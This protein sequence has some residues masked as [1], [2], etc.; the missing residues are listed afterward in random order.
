MDRGLTRQ[1]LLERL[2]VLEQEE[3]R[4]KDAERFAE[5]VL[6][7]LSAHIAIL[8]QDG[9]IIETNR[10]WK[11]FAHAN[12]IRMRPD[13]L[14]VNYI[15]LCESSVGDSAEQAREVARGI[16]A[17]IAGEMDEFVIDYPCHSPHEKRWFYMRATRLAGAGTVR[18]VVSHENITAL[19]LAEEAL[20]KREAE[21]EQQSR[22]LE[23]ANTALKVLLQQREHDKR[24]LEE[25][26]LVNVRNFIFPYLE[27]LKSACLAPQYKAYLEIMESHLKEI[28]SP[29][30][31]RLSLQHLQ[32][33]PQEIQ[34][35]ALVKDGRTTKDIAQTLSVSTNAVEFHRKNIR[36]KLGLNNVKTNLRSYLLSLS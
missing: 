32:F 25:N 27:K 9:V 19:K 28:V 17:V 10:T 4:R 8:N 16:R 14:A 5:A 30:L 23:E 3:G 13:T 22:H 33:T 20:R 35:A 21:L 26:V 24:E 36:K 18:V 1:E 12:A 11:A 7:S 31:C 15:Q 2:S 6:N 29:F 34:V